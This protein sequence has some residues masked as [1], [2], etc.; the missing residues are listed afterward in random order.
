MTSGG[1][2]TEIVDFPIEEEIDI[3]FENE[4][5][6]K[7]TGVADLLRERYSKASPIVSYCQNVLFSPTFYIY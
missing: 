1:S 4:P 3:D 2:G 6:K 7:P 5:L